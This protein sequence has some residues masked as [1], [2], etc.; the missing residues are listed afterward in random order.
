M[1]CCH[2]II[3][4]DIKGQVPSS[5]QNDIRICPPDVKS[6]AAKAG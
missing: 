4:R 5:G 2:K 6:E 3:F 1:R